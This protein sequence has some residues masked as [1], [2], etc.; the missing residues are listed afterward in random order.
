MCGQ[1]L[2]SDCQTEV[3]FGSKHAG[4]VSVFGSV[5]R[6][7]PLVSQ[8]VI[9]FSPSEKTSHLGSSVMIIRLFYISYSVFVLCSI[10]LQ[11][12]YFFVLF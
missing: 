8:V 3:I 10:A 9:V 1:S 11:K 12:D 2:F 4:C 7:C 6:E 5:H